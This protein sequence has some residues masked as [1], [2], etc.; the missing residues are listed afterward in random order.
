MYETSIKQNYK[1]NFQAMMLQRII[2][3]VVKFKVKGQS[4]SSSP[5][6]KRNATA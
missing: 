3:F 6:S 1:C 5:H 2:Y 4:S